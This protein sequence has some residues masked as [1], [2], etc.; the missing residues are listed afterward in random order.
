MFIDLDVLILRFTNYIML[1][2]FNLFHHWN[3]LASYYL[4][5]LVESLLER[6]SNFRPDE[7]TIVSAPEFLV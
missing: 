4:K 5:F 2:N 6:M 7:F 1:R 3:M